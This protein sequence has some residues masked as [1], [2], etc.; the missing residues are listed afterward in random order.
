MERVT[1][2][3]LRGLDFI[4]FD[5]SLLIRKELDRYFQKHQVVVNVAVEFD[6]IETIKQAVEIGMG[7]SILPEPTVQKEIIAKSLV[8]VPLAIRRLQRPIGIIHR[9]RKMFTP[10]ITRFIELIRE[11]IERGNDEN[12]EADRGG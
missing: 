12:G 11:T 2:D 8:A 6:N 5:R 3:Q 10:T 7:V 4:G 1:I 9:Q